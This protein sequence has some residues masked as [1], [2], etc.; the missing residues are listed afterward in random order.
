MRGGAEVR[1]AT[2]TN[3]SDNY[4]RHETVLEV[5]VQGGSVWSVSK[6]F[7]VVLTNWGCDTQS[8]LA[9]LRKYSR[10][11]IGVLDVKNGQR[12]QAGDETIALRK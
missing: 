11:L 12:G 8:S 7:V 1:Y 10:I 9:R 6:H 3:L 2:R 4:Q 5:Q